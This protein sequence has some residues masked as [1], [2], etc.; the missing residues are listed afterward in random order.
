MPFA[1]DHP[2][3]NAGAHVSAFAGSTAVP[4]RAARMRRYALMGAGGIVVAALVVLA[5]I[6]LFTK[7]DAGKHK[8]VVQISLITPPPP[9][10]PP[11]KPPEE[12]PKMKEE[13]KMEQPR[14]DPEPQTPQAPPPGPIGLDSA[15]SGPGD[16]F[17]LAG[18]AG[19]R[20]IITSGGG[21]GLS[22]TLFGTATARHIAQEL[23]RDPNLKGVRYTIEARVWLGRDGRF[24]RG[25]IL[26]G[27]GDHDLDERIREGLRHIG[28][29]RQPVPANL[30]QPLRIRVTSADA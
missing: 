24:E 21:G 6:G 15:G 23:G 29:L 1:T 14:P 7:T 10:P 9:P 4:T 18:R 26:H 28:A 19:G 22:L 25:E 11:P 16:S 17:G 5:L 13:V 27:T 8:Q 2:G 3:R 12:Q 30:P 20:D